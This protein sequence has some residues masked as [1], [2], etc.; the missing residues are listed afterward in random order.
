V[1]EEKRAKLREAKKKMSGIGKGSLSGMGLT[2]RN[3]PYRQKK[4]WEWRGSERIKNR[5]TVRK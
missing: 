5:I 1:R 3:D 2:I 4:R